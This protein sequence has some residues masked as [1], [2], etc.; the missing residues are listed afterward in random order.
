VLLCQEHADLVI[1]KMP[2]RA[3]YAIKKLGKVI[4]AASGVNLIEIVPKEQCETCMGLFLR[5]NE[6]R[7]ACEDHLREFYLKQDVRKL[8]DPT[9]TLPSKIVPKSECPVCLHG[10]PL[11]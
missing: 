10:T 9:F 3:R 8:A 5:E 2:R 7:L 11:E 1:E 4:K 6:P